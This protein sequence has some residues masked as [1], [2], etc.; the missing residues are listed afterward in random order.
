MLVDFV[1]KLCD[2]LRPKLLKRSGGGGRLSKTSSGD[3]CS[4]GFVHVVV[5][6]AEVIAEL[7]LA[8]ESQLRDAR[9][10]PF[11]ARNE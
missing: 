11:M 10:P 3:I 7:V 6:G 1:D 9:S 8:E 2:S 4:V 5:G